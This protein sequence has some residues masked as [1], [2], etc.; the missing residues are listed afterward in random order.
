M[1]TRQVTQR[2]FLMRPDDVTNNAFVFCL[3]IAALRTGIDIMFSCAMSNHHHTIIFD[4][5][6][7][8]PEFIAHFHKLF[9]KCQNSWHG[10]WENFWASRK[11]SVVRLVTRADVINKIVYAATNPVKANLV[12]RATQWPGVNTLSHFLYGRALRARRP[13]HF[14][15]AAGQ[16][17]ESV[18]LDLVMPPEFGTQEDMRAEIL[19]RVQDA[20]RTAAQQRAMTGARVLGRRGCKSQ[21]FDATPSTHAPRRKMSPTF[22]AVNRWAREEALQRKKEFLVAYRAARLAWIGGN[23]RPIFPVGTYWLRRFTP[24]LREFPLTC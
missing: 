2:M 18:E 6:G 20:E 12:E 23:A 15:S 24:L 19:A 11:T 8:Y 5:N 1:I 13:A 17:P 16:M 4:R 7:T 9:A 14:F 22:A 10:R 3:A 21:R